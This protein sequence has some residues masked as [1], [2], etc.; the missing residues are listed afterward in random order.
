MFQERDVLTV[1]TTCHWKSQKSEMFQEHDVLTV[2]VQGT[3]K[4][5]NGLRYLHGLD[6]TVGSKIPSPES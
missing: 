3:K 5:L 4:K 2:Y 1:T 6:K